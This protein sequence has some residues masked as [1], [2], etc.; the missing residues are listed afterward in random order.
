MRLCSQRFLTGA[1]NDATTDGRK[2][3]Y[4]SSTRLNRLLP[5][6]RKVIQKVAELKNEPSWRRPRNTKVTVSQIFNTAPS[7]VQRWWSQRHKYER[8]WVAR[9]ECRVQNRRDQPLKTMRR[10]GRVQLG[11]FHKAEATLYC[12]FREKRKQGLKVNGLWLRLRFKSLVSQ[13]HHAIVKGSNG[14]LI[15]WCARFNVVS[16]LR[17]AYKVPVEMRLQKIKRWH[18]RLVGRLGRGKQVH[19]IDGRWRVMHRWNVDQVGCSLGSF[20]KRTYHTKEH[21]E[22]VT[23]QTGTDSEVKR[24]CTLQLCIRY[25]SR[26][27]RLTQCP[28]AIIFRGKGIRISDEERSLWDKRVHVYFQPKAWVDRRICDEWT[29]RTFAPCTSYGQRD[30]DSS[31]GEWEESVIFTD[32]LKTQTK[33]EW[34]RL[35]WKTARTK[36][37]LFPVGLTDTLQTIDDGIGAMAKAHMGAGF[38]AWL[39]THSE[40]PTCTDE[41][42]NLDRLLARAVPAFERR[43]LLTRLLGDAWDHVLANY[44]MIKSGDKNGCTMDVKGIGKGNIRLQGLTGPYTFTS[45]DFGPPAGSSADEEESS[46]SDA[47]DAHSQHANATEEDAVDNLVVTDEGMLCCAVLCC[48]LRLLCRAVCLLCCAQSL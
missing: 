15:G 37:H 10:F 27:M 41:R 45:D 35:L 48:A 20:N 8:L 44:D 11:K 32:N 23:I 18:A 13:L 21:G 47:E 16:R 25:V 7:N 1:E 36:S 34:R 9:R 5:F 33:P 12:E 43:V 3:N 14:W 28:A 26:E 17:T 46:G 2:G 19:P 30:I 4:G 29:V 31:S 40:L 38:D 42:L 24:E 22:R 6:K 39:E